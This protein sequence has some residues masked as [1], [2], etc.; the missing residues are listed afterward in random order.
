VLGLTWWPRPPRRSTAD[1][2]RPRPSTKSTSSPLSPVV[3][4]RYYSAPPAEPFSI[5]VGQP[6]LAAAGAWLEP[7]QLQ[8]RATR[9]MQ[10]GHRRLR[11]EV[12]RYVICG[13]LCPLFLTPSLHVVLLVQRDCGRRCSRIRRCG[14]QT[15]EN[16]MRAAGRSPARGQRGLPGLA[17]P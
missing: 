13:L 1:L 7:G 3:I 8:G 10:I 2:A 14:V 15:E 16:K 11:D 12:C 4:S 5:G 17:S 6:H 9:P